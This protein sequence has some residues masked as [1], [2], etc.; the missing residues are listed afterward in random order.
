MLMETANKETW[1]GA[2]SHYPRFADRRSADERGES[3][4]CVLTPSNRFGP[5]VT[6][7][8]HLSSAEHV[9]PFLCW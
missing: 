7:I 1:S 4:E 2:S 6:N 9:S 3:A 8:F 5:A